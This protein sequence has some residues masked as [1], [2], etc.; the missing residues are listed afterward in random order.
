M[1]IRKLINRLNK[2]NIP[3]AVQLVF[4]AMT[5]FSFTLAVIHLIGGLYG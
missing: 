2:V 5:V 3:T 4:M 1:I